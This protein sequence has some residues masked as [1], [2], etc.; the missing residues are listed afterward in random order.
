MDDTPIS[1]DKRL[2]FDERQKIESLVQKGY[3]CSEISRRIGRSKNAIVVEI[4]L[5]GGPLEYTALKGQNRANKK[6]VEK[7]EKLHKHN[8]GNQTTFR[9]KQRIESLE[10]QLEI[11]FDTVKELLNDKKDK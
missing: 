9:F 11:L 10:M 3:S 4:K 7:K 6:Q 1:L 8:I 2:R 5:N